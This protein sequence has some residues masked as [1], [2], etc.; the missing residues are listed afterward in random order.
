MESFSALLALC[1]GNSPVTDGFPAQ[2]PVMWSF[3]VFFD[4]RLKNCW[5]NNREAGDLGYHCAHYD[6]TV[7]W[8]R[9]LWHIPA[10]ARTSA[11]SVKMMLLTL[12]LFHNLS[13]LL[14][15]INREYNVFVKAMH[16]PY[17]WCEC[18]HSKCTGWID[19]KFGRHI[20]CVSGL[21]LRSW[22][23]ASQK[24]YA[25]GMPGWNIHMLYTCLV[26]GSTTFDTDVKIC[27]AW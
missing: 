24:S 7:M 12:L 21:S 2:R 3:D 18:N 1:V 23:T 5:V 6:V 19:F 20:G 16:P 15:S 10:G 17:K 11:S 9:M 8:L 25:F 22:I 26:W 13:Y 27:W 14:Y 4:L